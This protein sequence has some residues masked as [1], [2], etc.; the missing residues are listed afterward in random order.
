[1]ATYEKVDDTTLK[2]SETQTV[3]ARYSVENLKSEKAQLEARLKKIDALLAEAV[4]LGIT[5]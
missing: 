1:M 4:K 2:E 5:V 3:E